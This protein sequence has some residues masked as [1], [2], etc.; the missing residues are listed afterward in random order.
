MIGREHP[1][2]FKNELLE[3]KETSWYIIDPATLERA[4]LIPGQRVKPD[5]IVLLDGATYNAL[6]ER[7]L[8]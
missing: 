3:N 6:L 8:K 1:N 7:N 5:A 2:P 4:V